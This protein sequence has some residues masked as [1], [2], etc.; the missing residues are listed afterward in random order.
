MKFNIKNIASS[1]TVLSLAALSLVACEDEPDKYEV[2][3]GSPELLCVT[4]ASN[5]D[6]L[7]TSAFTAT[8]VVLMGNNLRSIVKLY[9]NDREAVLN[10]SFMTDHTVFVNV[11]RAL[12]DNPTDKIYMINSAGDTTTYDFRVDISAPT[13]SSMDCEYV[14]PGEVATING[15]YLLT[16]D[17]APMV[18]TMP[19]G[20]E[21][22]DFESISQYKVSFKIPEGCT[23]AGPITVTTK[24]GATKSKLFNFNDDRGLMADFDGEG[25]L[26]S[27][28]GK[29]PQG[30]NISAKA[31]TDGGLTGCGRYVVMGPESDAG[32]LDENGGWNEAYKLS[33]WAGN[34]DGKPMEIPAGQP[35]APFCNLIDFTNFEKMAVKFEVCIPKETPWSSAA[36]QLCFASTDECAND[37]W[38]NNTYFQTP[39]SLCRGIWRPWEATGSYHTDGKW[40]T[41]TLPI[42]DFV[43]NM[44]GTKG[45]K[46]LKSAS[47][48]ASFTIYVIDGGVK[49]TPCNPSIRM[50]NIRAV[51][52]Y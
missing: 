41:V 46:P 17:E 16:Y 18:I 2:A 13:L 43:Y 45:E 6:S 28:N 11:P 52:I 8:R 14:A 20:T 50:D 4:T 30:W 24:Y 5:K 19:D 48:F 27:S 42:K 1:A 22:K 15:D 38:Q 10:T 35:G 51:T 29:V 34:W 49:G 25:D 3:G 40:V 37:S 9:F 21:I 23:E 7:I 33:Y 31:L 12:P 44:D 26:G 32:E 47:D 39:N 36:M